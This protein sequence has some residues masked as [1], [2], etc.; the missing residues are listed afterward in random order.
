MRKFGLIGK[1]LD[2]SWSEEYFRLKFLRE[3]ISDCVYENF[4]LDDL[5]GFRGL[6]M[7]ESDLSG[8]NVTIPYKHEVIRYIDELDPTARS[9]QAV[10]CIQL[11]G[12]GDSVH[13]KGYNTDMPAFRDTLKPLLV[14]SGLKA[15]VLGT[16]GAAG[17]VCCA[18]KE[19]KIDYLLVSRVRKE[20]ALCYDD[21]DRSVT[22]DYKIIIN[23]TPVGMFPDDK[24][25]PPLP[26]SCLTSYHLLYDLV[27][28][29]EETL[30]LKKGADAGARIK[31]GL[32]MLEMQAE[33]SWE[34]WNL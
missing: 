3:K 13:F 31:N 20:G 26:Y 15:M 1:S 33:L 24:Q 34:I 16:G 32:E 14:E 8:L 4:Q 23:A 19:L 7:R 12:K 30:F 5:K 29:P 25:C 11:S 6:V 17:A 27:Y 22:E 21:I 10:N 28:N 2:H 18:L 9:I